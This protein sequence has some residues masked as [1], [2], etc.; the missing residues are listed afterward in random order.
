MAAPAAPRP[1]SQ[2][3][4]QVR[5][6]GFTPAALSRAADVRAIKA[7]VS[8]EYAARVSDA[9]QQLPMLGDAYLEQQIAKRANIKG[10]PPRVLQW[11][12]AA[13]AVAVEQR[14]IGEKL[15]EPHEPT[16]ELPQLRFPPSLLSPDDDEP[17]PAERFLLGGIDGVRLLMCDLR[18]LGITRFPCASK[19][20]QCDGFC[21]VK[22]SRLGREVYTVLT[23]KALGIKK[24]SDFNRIFVVSPV[25]TCTACNR[26]F[27]MHSPRIIAKLPPNEIFHGFPCDASYMS[28]QVAVTR[29]FADV[30]KAMAL[31]TPAG[32]AGVHGAICE[33]NAKS[34]GRATLCHA[35]ALAKWRE[36]HPHTPLSGQQACGEGDCEEGE[37][38]DGE[39][40]E[41]ADSDVESGED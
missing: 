6:L 25:L 5:Q 3:D 34:R 36:R 16:G 29:E 24:L 38:E 32:V 8:S 37:E 20:K 11:A 12:V 4:E 26:N 1:L 7:S 40:A 18:E 27:D 2:L 23:G 28:S 31:E 13:A 15:K 17:P 22:V 9:A 30:L 21:R 39:D 14:A 10:V 33:M 41:S 19:K 35:V